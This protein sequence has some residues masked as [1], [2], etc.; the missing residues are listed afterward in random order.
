MAGER[1]I[2]ASYATALFELAVERQLEEAV[3]ADMKLLHELLKEN[4]N[5]V[6]VL[7]SPVIK[8]SKKVAILHAL[9]QEH[10]NE[11]TL[12]FLKLLVKAL[13]VV[14][15]DEIARQTVMLYKE[16]KG[17]RTIS[18]RTATAISEE[19]REALSLKLVHLLKAEIDLIEVIDPHLLGGFVVQM[20]DKRF[21]AS[22]RAKLNKLDRQF[23][24]NIYKKGF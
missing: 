17:I 8:G 6:H 2:A 20:E 13:R 23:D 5:L 4:R 22:I 19:T 3:Y 16:H 11:L 7:A 10:V 12:R 1:K 9:L 24:I 21:D 14:L 15:L 18:L